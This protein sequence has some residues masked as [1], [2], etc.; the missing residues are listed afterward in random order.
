M[1]LPPFL[2]VRSPAGG[3]SRQMRRFLRTQVEMQLAAERV[4]SEICDSAWGRRI[5]ELSADIG[6]WDACHLLVELLSDLLLQYMP[7]LLA[8]DDSVA[9]FTNLPETCTVVA[10]MQSM[11]CYD[12]I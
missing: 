5:A 3:S 9:L 12:N 10:Y 6:N 11:P 1:V 4:L 8:Q 2:Q 7:P